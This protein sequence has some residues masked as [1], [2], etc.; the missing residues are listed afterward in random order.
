MIFL[1]IFAIGLTNLTNYAKIITSMVAKI[2]SLIRRVKKTKPTYKEDL[3]TKL[4]RQ[5]LK[6]M[7][8]RG[9]ELP[10]VPLK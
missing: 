7:F 4:G 3:L 9:I 1:I 8:E 2:P 5:Q 10:V 6:V